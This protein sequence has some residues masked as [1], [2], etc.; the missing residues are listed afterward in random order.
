MREHIGFLDFDKN[1]LYKF[2]K[3]DNKSWL[4]NVKRFSHNL[5][6]LLFQPPN[7]FCGRIAE[8]LCLKKNLELNKT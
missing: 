3:H 1:P 8:S 7:F 2:I 5:S 6:T 4:K